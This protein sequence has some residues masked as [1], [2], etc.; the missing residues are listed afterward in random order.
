MRT[1]CRLAFLFAFLAPL[2]TNAQVFRLGSDNKRTIEATTT[3]KISVPSD[4]AIVKVGFDHIAETKDAAYSE[5]VRVGAKIIKALTDAGIPGEE[6]QT[7]TLNVG[8]EEDLPRNTGPSPKIRYSAEQQWRIHVIATDAQKVIDIAVAAGANTVQGVEWNVSD[9]QSLRAKAYGVALT[10]AKEMAEQSAVQAGVRLGELIS[11]INGEESEG[12]AKMPM[13]RK[14]VPVEV[15]ALA[16]QNLV[17]YPAK[18]EREATVTV[19]YG[20]AQ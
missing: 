18:V 2:S 8:R 11:I 19:I 14:M 7:E 9:P 16:K 1:I 5:T 12:F 10:R 6:I 4:S 17:L 13:A 3:E 15:E 20:I